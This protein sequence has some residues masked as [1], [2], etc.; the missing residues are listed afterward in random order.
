MF[1]VI[2]N[3]D[4]HKQDEMQKIICPMT[5]EDLRGCRDAVRYIQQKVENK[6]TSVQWDSYW[7][8]YY[9]YEEILGTL[10]IKE[11]KDPSLPPNENWEEIYNWS[12]LKSSRPN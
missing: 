7:H 11:K 2:K 1:G 8:H 4:L 6:D 9:L 12:I 5:R 10:G 3:F